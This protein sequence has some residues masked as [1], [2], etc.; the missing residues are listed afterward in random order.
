MPCDVMQIC[1]LT[2]LL[3]TT[4]QYTVKVSYSSHVHTD[5]E[6]RHFR[7]VNEAKEETGQVQICISLAKSVERDV[8]VTLTPISG[9]AKGM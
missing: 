2:V 4:A 8:P 6:A 3:I 1:Q 5:V 7:P 9:T